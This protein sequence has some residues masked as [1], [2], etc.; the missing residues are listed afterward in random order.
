MCV[1][2]LALPRSGSKGWWS[3][4]PLSVPNA[5]RYSS[6]VYLPVAVFFPGVGG[7]VVAVFFPEAQPVMLDPLEPFQP[8][9]AL[10]RVSL[11]HDQPQWAA[12][13]GGQLGAV[14]PVGNH[15]VVVGQQLDGQAR[16]VIGG[17][18]R[19]NVV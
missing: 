14:M 18:V 3:V 15:D 1:P 17:A 10:P 12:V 16:G 11:G 13:I 8:L 19:D 4:P 5:P 9:R 2:P 6:R 7:V